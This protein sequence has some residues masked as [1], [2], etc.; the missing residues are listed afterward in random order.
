MI[1]SRRFWWWDCA[2]ARLQKLRIFILFDEKNSSVVAP[3][4]KYAHLISCCHAELKINR[5]ILGRV[6]ND[7]RGINWPTKITQPNIITFPALLS[8]FNAVSMRDALHAKLL[9]AVPR[10][11]PFS[12]FQPIRNTKKYGDKTTF[13]VS[14]IVHN[15]PNYILSF[16]FL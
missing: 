16:Y 9:L 3:I 1:S 8:K 4:V 10:P 6:E 14:S 7:S 2:R 12:R 11:N 5:G 13:L 15:K